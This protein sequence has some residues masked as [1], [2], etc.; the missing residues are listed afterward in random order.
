MA[1]L[2]RPER[3]GSGR[4]P[5][6]HRPGLRHGHG[7][8]QRR[9]RGSRAG[10]SEHD[11][12]PLLHRRVLGYR[13]QRKDGDRGLHALRQ[14]LAAVRA[15]RSQ[16]AAR[17]V[18]RQREDNL[19]RI[20]CRHD[21]EPPLEAVPVL[22]P[23]V[24]H[25]CAGHLHGFPEIRAQRRD[26]LGERNPR[27][28]GFPRIRLGRQRKG[29]RQGH[30]RTRHLH[31]VKVRCRPVVGGHLDRDE[32]GALGQRHLV[33][34][35]AR[36]GVVRRDD[37]S[38]PGIGGGRRHDE[39]GNCAANRHLVTLLGGVEFQIDA[40]QSQHAQRGVNGRGGRIDHRKGN[41]H[42]CH[43]LAAAVDPRIGGGG[44]QIVAARQPSALIVAVQSEGLHV[45]DACRSCP[46][47]QLEA[48]TVN[49]GS[50]PDIG[51]NRKPVCGGR[52]QIQHGAVLDPLEILTG[53]RL[54][55]V[56]QN[57]TGNGAGTGVETARYREG[58]CRGR[59][60]LAAETG[61]RIG[62]RS[63]PV[64]A[65]GQHA[66]PVVPVAVVSVQDIRGESLG[67]RHRRR[68]SQR[69]VHAADP[70]TA[71]DVG[72]NRERACRRRRNIHDRP[73]SDLHDILVVVGIDQGETGDGRRESVKTARHRES[74]R[75]GCARLAPAVVPGI[76]RGC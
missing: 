62:C 63:D 36:V 37:S 40:A 28:E 70:G 22:A 55:G 53:A 50:A 44:E 74:H 75:Y 39:S 54:A 45:V 76:G 1:V 24:R 47:G 15:D 65:V 73:R 58:R 67:G 23:P 66:P 68:A 3:H 11:R 64:V 51:P 25:R 2:V 29:G 61:L 19:R 35:R 57:E 52:G 4:T 43:R 31:L 42:G 69:Q 21:G 71:P 10:Q 49:P 16:C 72:A 20:R 59:A 13:N 48:H 14:P 34:R 32:V 38:C 17:A 60:R 46:T 7:N 8:R 56:E 9:S 12:L 5:G 6:E 18:G 30:G 33:A 26:R 27:R 41:G